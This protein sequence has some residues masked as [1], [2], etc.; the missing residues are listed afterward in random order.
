MARLPGS[1]TTS[2]TCDAVGGF[3]TGVDLRGVGKG[4]MLA[5]EEISQPGG[6]QAVRAG[7]NLPARDDGG[8]TSRSRVLAALQPQAGHP[9]SSTNLRIPVGQR[10]VTRTNDNRTP[11]M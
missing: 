1:W 9:C 2:R 7:P 11:L 3:Y 6:T 5:W 10:Y 8:V 4:W